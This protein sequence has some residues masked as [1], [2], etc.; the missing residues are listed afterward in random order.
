MK[1]NFI[2][3]AVQNFMAGRR[4][5]ACA[6]TLAA[7]LVA[8]GL[9][10][11][12]QTQ[13]PQMDAL[14]AAGAETNQLM[15]LREGDTVKISFP[16]S[17]QLDTQQQIRRDG[18]INLPLVGDV[19]AAGMTPDALQKKLIDLYASQLV[20]KQVTVEVVSSAFP[21]YVT[22]MVLHPG[23]VGANRPMTALEA[24]ME[25]GG[26]DFGRANVRHVI[27]TRRVG[28]VMTHYTLDLKGELDGTKAAELFFMQPGDIIYV[29][30][31]FN[32]F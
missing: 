14:N 30:E 20:S 22:G 18:K 28:K 21:I 3:T 13:N 11:G 12:C 24:I 1:Q 29:P 27:V 4:W 15:N 5:L 17:S 26:F 2:S 23:T 32:M 7:G 16:G 9:L 8:A 6:V 31:R 25:A 19:A 10:A